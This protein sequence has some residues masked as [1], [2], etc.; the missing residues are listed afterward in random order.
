MTKLKALTLTTL[1]AI[2]LVGV[3]IG[4]TS[5]AMEKTDGMYQLSG[6]GGISSP[7]Y[8]MSVFQNPAAITYFPKLNVNVIGGAGQSLSNPI[9][10][11]G[12][13]YGTGVFG[14]TAGFQTQTAASTS[15][16]Y[17]GLAGQITSIK[18]ALGIS[19]TYGIS[20]SGGVVLNAG[21]LIT[22]VD[23]VRLGFTA[24][25]LTNSISEYG[26]GL[27]IGLNQSFTIMVDASANNT[28]SNINFMPALMAQD[29]NVGAMLGYGFG[30]QS[31]I[32]ILTG[33]TAGGFVALGKTVKLELYYNMLQTFFGNL[34]IHF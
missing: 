16:A 27:A 25:N 9:V 2:G 7:S 4:N 6:A 12:V 26:A 32:Q 14:L 13:G 30:N 29:Q 33:F 15:Q 34:T 18:T 24:L 5:F 21:I 19:G 11:G 17:F 28:L 1:G 31:S 8:S 10:G 20:P 23:K 22:P 3:S